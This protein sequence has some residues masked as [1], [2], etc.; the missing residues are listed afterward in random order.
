MH[1]IGRVVGI[2]HDRVEFEIV[3]RDLRLQ[4]R[5]D[6]R[7]IAKGV[8]G[9]EA[10]VVADVGERRLLILDHL[11]DVPVPGLR[12]GAAEFVQRDILTGDVLDHVGPG[13]EHVALVAHR[14][15]E[16]CLDRRIHCS[17][18]AFA[19]DDGYLRDEAPQQ[20]VT[21]AELRVPGKRGH[22]V[23][24]ASARRIVDSDDGA[25]HH[26]HPLHQ[27]GHLA[28]EHLADR[29]LEHR[30]VVAEDTDRSPVD[31]GVPG[32]HPVAEECGGVT[33]RLGQRADLQE[34]ARVD[35]RMDAGTGARNALLLPL[36]DGLLAT[37]FLC[38]LELF[39]Q[40]GQQCR[41]GFVGH[42]ACFSCASMRLMASLMCAPTFAMYGS[43]IAWM[44]S[45]PIGTIS[46]SATYGPHPPSGLRVA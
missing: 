20:L 24:D 5:V 7:R 25:A 38:Q 4:A 33:R 41:G 34:A 35:Q 13:D 46:R 43:S 26:R 22:R 21:A 36:G 2:G 17:A 30:L 11:M 15:H 37:G 18:S 1:V 14:Y 8:G 42:F 23:L 27:T 32:D 16:V 9:Q 3:R 39:T 45:P 44:C 10:Q 12:V 28:A 31:R 19:E 29:T 6:D 40:V